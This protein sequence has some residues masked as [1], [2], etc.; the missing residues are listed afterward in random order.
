MRIHPQER[1]WWSPG[2]KVT[3][4]AEQPVTI[5]P[6]G[7]EASFD[8]GTT[9]HPSRD[10][11]GRPG[12]LIAGANFP[13]PGDSAGGVTA[14]HVLTETVRALVRLRDTPETIIDGALWIQLMP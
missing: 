2:L 6:I 12:W 4:S 10:N 7:F 11:G 1:L 13:G 3:D 9:W 8:D 5:P 14:D